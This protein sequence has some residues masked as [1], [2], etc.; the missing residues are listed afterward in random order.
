MAPN[1]QQEHQADRRVP[2]RRRAPTLPRACSRQPRRTAG[3]MRRRR[4]RL[5]RRGHRSAL[6]ARPRDS[7]AD[8]YTLFVGT[9]STHGTNVAVYPNLDYDPVQGLR[10]GHADRDVAVHAA[11]VADVRREI[12]EGSD[13]AGE[14][15]SRPAQLRVVR[16]RQHQ[17]LVAELF[18][19]L[20]GIDVAHVPYRGSA[21]AMTD[22]IAGRVQYTFD[23]PPRSGQ[24][25]GH[26]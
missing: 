7:P 8:G 21:P 26:R 20:A 15:A 18:D 23:G 14:G 12:S 13:R 4:K 6:R 24:V 10:A 19:S 9:P 17:S 1:T 3:S 22:L 5:R 11:D 16:Q 2:G 25:K